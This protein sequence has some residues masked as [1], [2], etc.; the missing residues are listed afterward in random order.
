MRRRHTIEP[1]QP[2]PPEVDGKQVLAHLA[3][4]S[5]PVS[6]REIAHG[7]DLKHRGRRFLPR[8][9]QQLKKKGEI[10]ELSG[11][12]Y[13]LAGQKTT[14]RDGASPQQVSAR[15]TVSPKRVRDP[16]LVSGRI[17]AHRD[18]Y[19]FVVPDEPM[20]RVEGDLFIGPDNLG[21]AMHGDH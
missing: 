11:G 19:G 4:L 1:R 7:M 8:L 9:I 18:G 2:R 15:A 17:V 6:I 10:E 14:P 20:P 3:K 13:R 16:N 5:K 12:R 21:D